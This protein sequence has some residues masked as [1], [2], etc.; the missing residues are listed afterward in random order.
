[1]KLRVLSLRLPALVVTVLVAVLLT[2]AS[3]GAKKP[4]KPPSGGGGGSST[5]STY[6]KNYANVLNGVQYDLTPEDVQATPDGGWIALASTPS[7]TNGVLVAWLLKTSAV[8]APQWQ[9]EVGCLAAAPG[10]YSI[11][12]SLQQT[13][14][15]GYVLAGGTIGCGSDEHCSNLTGFL[16]GL[17]EKV[18]STGAVVWARAYSADYYG[19]TFNQIKQTSDGGYVAV[20]QRS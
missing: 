12:V 8:G 2:P 6:V 1:M 14:D 3:A 19:T 4:P 15:G 13:S 9:K 20:L 10:D 7:A 5:T 17:I 16:C 18:D 11:G